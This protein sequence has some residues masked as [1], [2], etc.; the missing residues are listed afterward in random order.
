MSLL[1]L[2]H[3]RLDKEKPLPGLASTFPD[4]PQ[5]LI[6][7]DNDYDSQRLEAA[8]GDVGLASERTNNMAAGCELARS[9]DFHVIFS[10]PRLNDGSWMRLIEVANN[11]GLSFEVILLTRTFDLNQWGE[12]LQV[13]AFDV[14][15]IL[16]DLPKAAEAA[17]SALGAAY[18]KRFG[19][20]RKSACC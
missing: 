15:D 5:V 12:A 2:N 11:Y 1:T 19:P 7:C 16:R 6:V 4:M 8:F 10:S 20:G 13:G 9:G 3:G 17:K 14:L 18:L